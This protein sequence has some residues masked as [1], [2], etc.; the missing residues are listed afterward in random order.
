MLFFVAVLFLNSMRKVVAHG[1]NGSGRH[2]G[3]VRC[4]IRASKFYAERNMYLFVSTLFLSGIIG[5]M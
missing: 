1:G 4:E 5:Y 3:E 2:D